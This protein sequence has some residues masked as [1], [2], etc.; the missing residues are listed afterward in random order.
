M[1][2]TLKTLLT[3]L[4]V[5][6]LLYSVASAYAGIDDYPRM[7]EMHSVICSPEAVAVSKALA[8]EIDTAYDVRAPAN[9]KTLK[10]AGWYCSAVLG[11]GFHYIGINCRNYAPVSAGASYDYNGRR[12]GDSLFPLNVSQF[13]FALHLIVAPH[14][15]RIT[16]EVFDW[17]SVAIH[18]CPTPA[19]GSAWIAPI[20]FP[21]DPVGEAYRLLRD[22]G[23]K[24]D[25]GIWVHDGTY[26][27]A[28]EI[29]SQADLFKGA[30]YKKIRVLTC[31]EA[32]LSTS[33]VSK[34]YMELWNAF[35]GK[36]S[37]GELYF[38][39]DDLPWATAMVPIFSWDHDPDIW[40]AGWVVGRDPDYLHSFFHPDNDIP[41]GYNH[42]GIN[43]PT[44]NTFLEQLKYTKRAD[45]T[46]ITAITELQSICKEA[47][48]W[49][50]MLAPYIV[51]R[52]AVTP[53]LFGV[54]KG[55]TGFFEPLG[56]TAS[57]GWTYD[58]IYKPGTNLIKMCNPGTIG[59]LNPL[60]A[61]SV[62]EWNILNRVY[63]SLIAIDP[64]TKDDKMWAAGKYEMKE[65]KD[66]TINAHGLNLTFW[67]RPG[68]KWHDGQDYNASSAK[69]SLDFLAATKPPRYIDAWQFYVRSEVLAPL[70]VR[71]YIN[72]TGFWYQYDIAFAAMFCHKPIWEKWWGNFTEAQKWEPWKVKYD[73]WTGQTG[74]GD[75]KCIVGTG[76]W[77]FV[78]Y[79]EVALTGRLMANRPFKIGGSP[80]WEYTGRYWASSFFREDLNFDG[81]V[82]ILDMSLAALAFGATPGHA[83]WLDG[84]CDV[85]TNRV[86]NIVDLAKIALKWG[87]ITLPKIA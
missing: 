59:T 5:V 60:V 20:T 36:N 11:F 81:T 53:N 45:G 50:F 2:K 12:P 46:V 32:A 78:E 64:Y 54:H 17:T 79:D 40:G 22:A 6:A 21:P 25:T 43:H 83:R 52:A 24:N 28:G 47:Q 74:H 34:K 18:T 37:D 31:P 42:P 73:D 19:A 13:R 56:Y 15:E 62:Y 23:F 51:N 77:V 30:F 3:T 16:K 9:V 41:K 69:W 29:R 82:N 58:F 86:V 55:V 66:A 87:R 33:L 14:K 67:I 72:I 10:D 48:S 8:C 68:I 70:T 35:F 80:V 4:L 39:Q 85:D 75:L 44:L 71:V 38:H 49:I 7:D 27:P 65:W 61:G 76:P 1:G 63:D 26:G 84:Q 57:T